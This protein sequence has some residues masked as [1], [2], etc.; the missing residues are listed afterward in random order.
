MK[1]Y[2]CDWSNYVSFA[3]ALLPA[4]AM[5]YFNPPDGD[6]EGQKYLIYEVSNEEI[7]DP[8]TK[9]SLG[10]LELVKGTGIITHVQPK[11]STIESCIYDKS[12]IKTIR[13]NPMI[14]FSEY[15]ETTDSNENQRP[16]DN[17]QIGDLAKRVN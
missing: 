13:R 17:P 4:F 1:K 2:F 15:I 9:E 16:F 3:L 8:D 10:F 14:P 11:I 5:Y 6:T 12:P 7:F